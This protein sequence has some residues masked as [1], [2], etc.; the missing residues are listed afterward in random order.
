M[1]NW[2][3]DDNGKTTLKCRAVDVNASALDKS[4]YLPLPENPN[5]LILNQGGCKWSMAHYLSSIAMQY[6]LITEKGSP[7][8]PS[9]YQN[10][11]WSSTANEGAK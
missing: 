9:I 3:V 11:Y 5:S 2:C 6:F 7:S 1:E 10:P 8:N 4:T